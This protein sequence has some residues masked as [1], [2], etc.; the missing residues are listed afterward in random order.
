[1]SLFPISSS[2]ICEIIPQNIFTHT[3]SQAEKL[4]NKE[5]VRVITQVV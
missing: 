2:G 4:H 1:M 3:L 5:A